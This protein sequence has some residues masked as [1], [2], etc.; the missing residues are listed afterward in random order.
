MIE[1][2]GDGVPVGGFNGDRVLD[3]IMESRAEF[4]ADDSDKLMIA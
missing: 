1:Q 2:T 3:R 4:D